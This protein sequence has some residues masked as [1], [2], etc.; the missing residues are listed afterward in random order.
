MESDLPIGKRTYAFLT[1]PNY[2]LIALTNAIEPLRMANRVANRTLYDWR[3][4]SLKGDPVVASSG[5][6]MT[7][8]I[9]LAD[10]GKVDIL[11][12]CGGIDVRDT[13]SAQLAKAL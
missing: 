7:P 1:L 11:F 9:A 2:S 4:V 13:V 5:L 8:T 10:L 12:V 6:Q 3:I